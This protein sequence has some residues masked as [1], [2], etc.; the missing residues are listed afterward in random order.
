MSDPTDTPAQVPPETAP[1]AAS[2][3]PPGPALPTEV[4]ERTLEKY[5][6]AARMLA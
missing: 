6:D 3:P 5:R 1:Q 2:E 4:V